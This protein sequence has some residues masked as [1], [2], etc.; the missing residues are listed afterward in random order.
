MTDKII[1]SD[2]SLCAIVRD[3]MMNPAGGIERFVESHV[4]YVEEAVIA[5]TGSVDGTREI[6]EEMQA[7]YSNLRVVDIPFTGYASTRNKALNYVKTKKAFILD[8]DELLCHKKP[9][10]DWK[11]L[12][13]FMKENPAPSYHFFFDIISPEIIKLD[14]LSGHTLRLL[15]VT[16]YN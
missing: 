1:L 6:L 10:N 7:K 12:D 5:D 13:Q 3:E 9:Q 14:K 11:I 15:D 4:P 8:A 2:V 16:N